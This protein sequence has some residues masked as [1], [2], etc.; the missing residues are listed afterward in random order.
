MLT[1][2]VEFLHG[3]F[4]A[5]PEGTAHTGR[6]S[7]GEWP[8]APSRLFDALVAAD[9]TGE[10]CR[11]TD[12]SE[13]EVLETAPCPSIEASTEA[14]H[15]KLNDR[16]VVLQRGGPVKNQQQEYVARTAALVR[17]GVRVT[18]R[19]PT[20]QY[21]WPVE[22]D[23]RELRALQVRAARVGYLGCADSP[24]RVHIERLSDDATCRAEAFVPDDAGDVSIGVPMPGRVDMLDAA[25]A[26]WSE[27]GASVGRSQF[28]ALL[29]KTRYRSP[30]VEER[31]AAH[32][33]VVA[34]LILRPAVSGRRVTAVAATFKAAVLQ[35]FQD[36]HGEEPPGVLHGHG[37][38]V[39]GYDLAR[40]LS[41]PDVGHAHARGRIH[42]VALWLPPECDETIGTAV[43][44]AVH[45]I[46]R[47]VG[48]GVNVAAEIWD[49]QRRP[50]AARLGRWTRLSRRWVTAFPAIHER[51]L[52]S[53]LEEVGRWCQHAGLPPPV[54]FRSSRSPLLK[55]G[56]SLVPS[57]VHR[58][59]K[60]QR[61]YSHVELLFDEPVAGPVVIGSGRQRGFGLCLPVGDRS[62]LPM[63]THDRR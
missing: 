26:A 10:R 59:G 27:Q 6:L 55:G 34:V 31:A 53:T 1:A 46:R 62:A 36:I 52:P 33:R 63:P 2:T 50:L 24:V 44:E 5:D 56:A 4:R 11:H 43:R 17:P 60:P 30:S 29:T 32:G 41:L 42:A 13:L 35:R 37:F 38:E 19:V 40:Y 16:F 57:E 49:G 45:S 8:P 23:D 14:H 20:V 18:P 61:P 39:A 48:Q 47:L 22:I 3:T 15:Q 9:G 58:P 21:H 54:S 25:F 7:Q 28:P 12:G 51:H